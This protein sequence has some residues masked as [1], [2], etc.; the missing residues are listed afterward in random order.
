MSDQLS[1]LSTNLIKSAGESA[2]VEI[3]DSAAKLL[4]QD[5]EYRIREIAEEA[6]KFM[7]HSH[8]DILTTSDINYAL[9]VRNVEPMYGLNST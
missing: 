2:G 4:A 6:R 5:V 1:V 7:R 9:R 8:R 3:S